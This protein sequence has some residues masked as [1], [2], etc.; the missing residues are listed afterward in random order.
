MYIFVAIV[1]III[2]IFVYYFQTNNC[3][4]KINKRFYKTHEI[5]PELNNIYDNLPLIK[6]EVEKLSNWLPWPEK[7]LYDNSKKNIT[8]SWNVIP[9]CGFGFWVDS[10]TKQC[11][12]ITKFLKSIPGLKLALLSKL[13]PYM[14]LKPHK[15]WANHSN[16]SIRCHFG[17]SIPDNCYV[18]VKDDTSAEEVRQHEQDSWLI[19]DDSKTH[20]AENKS[21][22]D[23]IVLIV[24][25]ERPDHIEIGKSSVG[26][27]KE[28]IDFVNQV[29][30]FRTSPTIEKYTKN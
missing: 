15:G 16:Y 4:K 10:T 7:D 12:V 28:L 2:V 17:I 13:S 27:S 22:K 9:F 24:D 11:P 1:I 14:K 6:L 21:E 20:W 29:K 8:A 30:K 26:D 5:S 3:S 19:F 25:V 23:R 18:S